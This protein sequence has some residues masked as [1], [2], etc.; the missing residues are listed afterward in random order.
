MGKNIKQHSIILMLLSQSVI[1]LIP[2]E[3][4]SSASGQRWCWRNTSR[5]GLPLMMSDSS[6]VQ[7]CLAKTTSVNCLSASGPFVRASAA[8]GNR[9]QTFM[10][11]AAPTTI[12]VLRRLAISMPWFKIVSIMPSLAWRQLRLSTLRQTIRKTT[13]DWLHW[14]TLLTGVS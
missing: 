4:Q 3:Q 10:R 9:L 13:W 7:P 12:R 14:R 11:S 6:R 5:R 8:F 1:V 2:S